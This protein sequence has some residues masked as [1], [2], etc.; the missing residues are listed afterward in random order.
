MKANSEKIG[1]T[2][3]LFGINIRRD[4]DLSRLIPRIYF[5]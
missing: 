4:V 3:C 2:G 5:K 1:I